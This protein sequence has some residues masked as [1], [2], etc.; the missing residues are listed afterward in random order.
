MIADVLSKLPF[1]RGTVEISTSSSSANTGSGKHGSTGSCS[2]VVQSKY[3]TV[4]RLT[5][6]SLQRLVAEPIPNATVPADTTACARLSSKDSCAILQEAVESSSTITMM[7]GT[8]AMYAANANVIGKDSLTTTP[9]SNED[10]IRMIRS[11]FSA[12]GR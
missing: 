10:P 11:D 9:T 2:A 8:A 12:V 4:G 6:G 5:T 3:S 1:A 7:A